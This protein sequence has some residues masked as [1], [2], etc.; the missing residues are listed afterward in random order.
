MNKMKK[1]MAMLLSCLLVLSLAF[2]FGPIEVE[3]ANKQI[4]DIAKSNS[5]YKA[6]KW[7]IDKDYMQLYGGNKF[8]SGTLVMEW[9]MLQFLA[10]LDSNY[11][12]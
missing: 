8:Q 11:V 4:S 1:L 10:K 5:K 7:A 6:A 3:A 9:Q 2:P 12:I